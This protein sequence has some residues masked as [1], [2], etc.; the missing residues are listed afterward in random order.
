MNDPY[1]SEREALRQRR[2][3]LEA[4]LA[5]LREQTAELVELRMRADAI[6]R[7][8]AQVERQLESSHPERVISLAN[9]RVASPCNASWEAMRGDDRVRFCGICEKHVYNLSGMSAAEAGALLASRGDALCVRFFQRADGTVLTADCPVAGRRKRRRHLAIAV[10]ASTAVAAT[11]LAALTPPKRKPIMGQPTMPTLAN[12]E[13]P[14]EHGA[15]AV[16]SPPS[17]N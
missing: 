11:A 2:A 15:P 16:S 8:L 3:L 6:A 5:Q 1:R 7:E 4:E 9:V 17:R 13:R 12:D 14:A 10:A